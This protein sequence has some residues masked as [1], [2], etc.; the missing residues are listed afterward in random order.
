QT[1]FY[2]L[3][4]VGGLPLL[5]LSAA[6]A[7]VGA[8][9]IVWRETPAPTRTRFLLTAAVVVA[10]CGTWSPRPQV[11]S[12]LLIMVTIALLRARRHVWLP[13]LFLRSE[14]RRVG[15]A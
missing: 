2:G 10:A 1:I 5:T 4:A 3:F 8:W 7:V 12:L 13:V 9:A 15:K 14:E 6:A 11:L